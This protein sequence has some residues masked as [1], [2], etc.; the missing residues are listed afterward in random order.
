[1]SLG[2]TDLYDSST[3]LLRFI[4]EAAANQATALPE[5]RVLASG[6]AVYD[7]EMVAVSVTQVLI[8][9]PSAP[10]P[11]LQSCG[12]ASWSLQ[13]DLAI[14]RRAAEMPQGPRGEEPP[15]V[16]DLDRDAMST[17][18]DSAILVDAVSRYADVTRDATISLVI[19]SPQGGLLSTVASVSVPLWPE[20][21]PGASGAFS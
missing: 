13:A 3:L 21:F 12:P 2:P 20:A 15:L 19:G 11:A 16:E 18:V 9:L 7:C 6:G 8:G 4:E 5:R 1:V 17:S 14:V 10:E